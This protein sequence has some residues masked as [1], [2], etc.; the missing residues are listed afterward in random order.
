M[1]FISIQPQPCCFMFLSHGTDLIESRCYIKKKTTNK[2]N[3]KTKITSIK[4]NTTSFHGIV[5]SFSL[6]CSHHWTQAFTS[7]I[8]NTTAEQQDQILL[9]KKK[10]RPKPPP[11]GYSTNT[12]TWPHLCWESKGAAWCRRLTLWASEMQLWEGKEE[13][14]D[15]PDLIT[16]ACLRACQG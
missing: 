14:R 5:S 15:P 1:R 8:P 4:Q 7:L 16:Q 3:R 9:I 12:Q 2:P 13:E 10:K 6:V 11:P